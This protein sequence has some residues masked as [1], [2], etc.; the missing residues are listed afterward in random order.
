[1][2]LMR[3][4]LLLCAALALG[5]CADEPA[6]AP[7]AT[8]PAP[9]PAAAP[10][11]PPPPAPMLTEAQ[12]HSVLDAVAAA[13]QKHDT[14]ALAAVFTDDA[15]FTVTPFQ[16]P[17][18]GY[19]KAEYLAWLDKQ[20]AKN[21]GARESQNLIKLVVRTDGGQA[22]ARMGAESVVDVNGYPL[23][24]RYENFY[25]V[26]LRAGEP[27]VVSLVVQGKGVSAGGLVN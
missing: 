10:A 19:D 5:G 16:M 17:T 11:P 6:P 20:F 23:A 26:E 21:A 14:S 12:V 18:K 24:Q 4:L 7:V 22:T 15:K 1:M 27:K 3:P 8:V 13:T 2:K 9:A 25:T